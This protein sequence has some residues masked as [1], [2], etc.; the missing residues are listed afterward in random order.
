MVNLYCA[1]MFEQATFLKTI[2]AELVYASEGKCV[3]RLALNESHN[4]QDGFIHA[5]VQATVADH[6][7]GTAVGSLLNSNQLPLTIEFKINFLR[8]SVGKYIEAIATVIKH[9]RSISLAECEVYTVNDEKKLLTAKMM[10]TLA[11]VEQG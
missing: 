9:G 8:P 10:S 4:Q 7:C 6:A 5:G 3:I 1:K 11:V 2:G